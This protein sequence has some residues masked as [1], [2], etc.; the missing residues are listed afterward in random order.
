[1][2]GICGYAGFD[3][4]EQLLTRMTDAIEHRGPDDSGFFLDHRLGLGM[5]RLS[6]ID[7]AGGSQ[8]ILNEDKTAVI[9]F[10]GEIYNYENLARELKRKG[11]R[12]RS[13]SD[14]E[15]VLHLYEEYG[16]GCVDYLRGMFAF[17]I[18]D[19]PHRKLF[20]AR[21]RL[22]IK[23]LYYWVDKGKL[24]FAS[25]IKSIL[26]CDDVPREP[27]MPAVDA[28]LTLRYVPGP[29]TMFAGIYKVPAGH[30]ML[31][32]DD[33]LRLECYWRLKPQTGQYQSDDYY[34]EKFADLFEESVAMRMMSEV[35]L[36]AY[37]SGGIDSAAIVAA[38]S[39]HS[40]RPVQTFT[41]GF[42]W[43]GDELTRAGKVAGYLGCD[44][45]EIL[46]RMD[47][48][49]LLPKIIW[50]LDEPVGDAIIVPMYQ[51]SLLARQHVK[52]VLTGDGAD[53]TLAGYFPHRVMS[54]AGRYAQ[55]APRIIHDALI[56]PLMRCLP[57][58][59][60]NLAFDY[61]AGLGRR[62]KRKLLDYLEL[63]GKNQQSEEYHFLISLFDKRDKS[64]FYAED[65][66]RYLNAWN[67][68]DP[69]PISGDIPYLDRLLLL[70]YV[71]WLPDDILMKQ[72]K[73]TMANSVESR[74]PFLDHKLVEFLSACPPHLKLKGMANKLLLRNYV[75]KLMPAETAGQR[76]RPFYIPVQQYF[77]GPLGNLVKSCLS[78]ERVKR[79][80]YFKWESITALHQLAEKG[81]FIYGKQLF[82][83]VVLEIWHRIFIDREPGWS[84]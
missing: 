64:Y 35:P 49:E 80:G 59:L 67:P 17:A 83:L 1:V 62:G 54:W 22:G 34:H 58:Q 41:V 27:F 48:F 71:H 66:H 73:M 2:C 26:E 9:V 46:C 38:M 37:L 52:V 43:P 31:H 57:R 23:P 68:D 60:L 47:D 18:Y 39:R 4:D 25:E 55:I 78:E 45:H 40:E 84:T 81:D 69:N 32:R 75:S 12:F 19:I 30:F 72:D 14:T 8:P 36:G 50:H 65:M 24:V 11:H 61:P 42:D 56:K 10:N 3:G 77:S 63:V 76:K 5:H 6:I 51:L 44:H 7:V 53:E 13:N 29:E 82:A 74:V 15:V 20:I 79:R 21:D 28:Y 70:Q 16:T 33:R